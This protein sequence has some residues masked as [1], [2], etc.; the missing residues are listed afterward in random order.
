MVQQKPTHEILIISTRSHLGC[1]MAHRDAPYKVEY[2]I[3]ECATLRG[4][5]IS[6]PNSQISKC[7]YHVYGN[8]HKTKSNDSEMSKRESMCG[9]GCLF[10]CDFVAYQTLKT[11]NYL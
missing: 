9:R 3:Y 8:L 11:Q 1:D 7:L 2:H 6:K 5:T 10:S 4:V